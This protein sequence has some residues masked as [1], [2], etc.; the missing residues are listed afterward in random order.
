MARIKGRRMH[1]AIDPPVT[2]R[3]DD[4]T[5][6]FVGLS[7]LNRAV[8]VEYDVDPP[9]NRPHPHGAYILV[10]AVTDDVSEEVYPTMWEDFEW[11][12]VAPGRTTTRL[13]QR[14]PPEAR[15]LHIEVRTLVPEERGT[16]GPPVGG[17][18]LARFD[19][20]LPAEHGV[21]WKADAEPER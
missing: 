10:I 8:M 16:L 2:V 15:L 7:L 9:L 4:R 19:V 11:P 1:L 20:T 17:Q 13:D 21:E 3:V 14:P 12:H 18:T 6:K 5:V